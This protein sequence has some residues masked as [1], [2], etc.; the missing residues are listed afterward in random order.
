MNIIE[1]RKLWFTLSILFIASGLVM[2][3]VGGVNFGIDFT[4]GTLMEI[5]L[6]QTPE[7]PEVRELLKDFD[8]EANINLLGEERTIVQIRSKVDFSNSERLEI[9]SVFQ[10]KYQLESTS[11]NFLLSEQFGPSVGKEIQRKA[12][13]SIGIAVI[14][15]LIYITFRFE[16]SFGLAAIVALIHD[17]LVVFTIYSLFR[18][19]INGPFVAAILTILGYSINDTIVIFDRVRENLRF[20]KKNDYAQVANDSINQTIVRSINTS[21]TTLIT[22]VALYVLGVEQIKQFALPLM[23]GVVGGTYSSLFIA[24]PVWVMIKERQHKKTS[25]KQSPETK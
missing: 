24:S 3:L 6:N 17:V 8:S 16:I 19:P 14:G 11:K 12:L 4:G 25:F 7:V 2:S 18:I 13:L 9:F 20:L 23:A 5:E 10:E 22:I 15:M 21:L 1:K